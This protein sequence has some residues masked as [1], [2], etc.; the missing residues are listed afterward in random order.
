MTKTCYT[1][2]MKIISWNVNGIRAWMK[3]EG[4]LDFLKKENPDIVCFQETKAQPNQIEELTGENSPK[5]EKHHIFQN[6]PFHYWHSAEKKGYSSTGIISKMKPLKVWYGME[7]S[8]L[9]NEGRLINAEF[10]NFILVNVYTPNAKPDLARLNL[11]YDEWDTA[12]LKHLKKL[13]KKKPVIVCG[14]FNVAHEEIDIARPESNKTTISFQGK[15]LFEISSAGKIEK[16]SNAF[17]QG[18]PAF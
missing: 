4:T 15:I 3:K 8:P 16:N 10:E 13:E 14:D 2:P 12:F 7:N 11:R 5:K 18:V 6:Y 17:L 9:E 1:K